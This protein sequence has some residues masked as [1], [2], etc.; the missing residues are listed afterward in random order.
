MEVLIAA[1]A[2]VAFAIYET[3]RTANNDPNKGEG[4][5]NDGDKEHSFKPLQPPSGTGSSNPPSA[6][7]KTSPAHA[8]HKPIST[9]PPTTDPDHGGSLAPLLKPFKDLEKAIE[10]LTPLKPAQPSKPKGR[11]YCVVMDKQGQ[12]HFPSSSFGN[13]FGFSCDSQGGMPTFTGY[14]HGDKYTG[15]WEGTFS[16]P[17]KQCSGRCNVNQL[18]VPGDL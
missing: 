3:R 18:P 1:G 5:G 16:D 13:R 14:Y 10:H 8:P 11:K 17:N 7:V 9:T 6:P 12:W 2:I 15:H 4:G